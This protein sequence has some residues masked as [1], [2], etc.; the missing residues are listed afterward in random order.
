[1]TRP[2]PAPSPHGR[3]DG[4]AVL[5]LRLAGPLQSWGSRSAFNRR[6]TRPEPT[7]SGVIGLLAAAAGLAREDPLD[8][9]LPLRLGIRV[10]Q[11]GTL[12]RDYHTV[13]DYRGRPL[14]QTGVSGKGIQKPTSPAKHTHVTTRY[15][16]QDAVFVAALA[17]PRA[18]L[19]T[20]GQAVRAPAFPLALGRRSCP[21]TQPL[22]L[23][24]HEGGLEEM[25]R[26]KRWQASRRTHELYAAQ[27]GRERGL[28]RPL[29]PARI[30]RSVTLEDPEGDD[31]LHDAPLSFDPHARSFTSR[32]VRHG[33]L[34]IPTDFPPPDDPTVDDHDH[35]DAGHDPFALLG[36]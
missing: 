33:W 17:G 18:L 26:E 24:V 5:L 32:R 16:L 12:L 28:G 6:E 35:D 4:Q 21:P 30:D 19:T 7:K 27:R 23:G 29:Y 3:D 25:L 2:A 11:P 10:D 15:Y 9:L 36:W 22:F 14:P 1:M 8:E 34:S 20:L 31:V 13:S